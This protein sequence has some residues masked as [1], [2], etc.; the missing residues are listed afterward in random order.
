M[1]VLMPKD[2]NLENSLKFCE[3]LDELEYDEIY[4]YN[5]KNMS[6]VEPFG[7]LI[8]GSKIRKFKMEKNKS[9]HTNSNYERNGYAGHMGYFKSIGVDFGKKPGEANGNDNYIPLTVENVN[10]VY[11]KLYFDK[12][13][14]G[15]LGL[16]DYIERNIAT[17]LANVISRKDK[18]IKDNLTF[19][20]SELIRNVFEHSKSKDIWYSG[21]YWPQKDLV[22]ISILDEGTG[23]TE[24]LRRNKKIEFSGDEEALKL[25]VEPGVTKAILNGKKLPKRIIRDLDFI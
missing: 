24:S 10:E 16:N 11:H 21:Q 3:L 4:E 15:Y 25:C 13:Y 9:Y 23:I 6:T 14:E 12:A 17:A 22:E 2:F 8:I 19:C 20:I 18:V 5:Y 1:E 7:M